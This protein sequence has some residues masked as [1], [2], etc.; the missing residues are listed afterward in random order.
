MNKTIFL[1]VVFMAVGYAQAEIMIG[2]TAEWM[3]HSSAIIA[4]AIPVKVDIEKGPGDVQFTKIRF[5]LEEVL[6]GPPSK[7]DTITVFDYD[8]KKADTLD[9]KT[10]VTKSKKLLIFVSIEKNMFPQIRGKYVFT[11]THGLFK[12]AFYADQTVEHLFTSDGKLL[13]GFDDLL[14]RT[15]A[16][17]KAEMQFQNSY[18]HGRVVRK[19]VGLRMDSAAHKKLY[20][21]SAVFVWVPDYQKSPKPLIK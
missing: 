2:Y 16:Q 18:P 3:S 20:S 13:V 14:K 7:G 15:H 11:P 19:S 8:Y 17:V 1:L 4:E 9:M 6:K 5:R 21:G 12:P 10:A